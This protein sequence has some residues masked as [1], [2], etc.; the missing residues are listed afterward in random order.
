MAANQTH[1][2]IVRHVLNATMWFESAWHRNTHSKESIRAWFCSKSTWQIA[3]FLLMHMYSIHKRAQ[4]QAWISCKEDQDAWWESDYIFYLWKQW[5]GVPITVD[6]F[7]DHEPLN[8]CVL[9][10]WFA[11]LGVTLIVV[12]RQ[13]QAHFVHST[14][15]RGNI[16]TVQRFYTRFQ[17]SPACPSVKYTV[18]NILHLL[19]V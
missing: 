19:Y 8:F 1:T 16:Y 2:H 18:Y 15:H 7:L 11:R 17:H 10:N 9:M 5:G 3:P 13:W 4:R 12:G 14:I 6:L